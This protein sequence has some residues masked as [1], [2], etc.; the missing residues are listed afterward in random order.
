MI[1]GVD[2]DVVVGEVA[3]CTDSEEVVADDDEIL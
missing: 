2:V 3:D 1:G